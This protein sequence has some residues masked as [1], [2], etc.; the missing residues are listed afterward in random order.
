M[1]RFQGEGELDS[2]PEVV[3]YLGKGRART[4]FEAAT[5]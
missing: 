5:H 4:R 1:A 3:R 2:D